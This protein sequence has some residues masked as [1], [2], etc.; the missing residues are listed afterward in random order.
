MPSPIELC[1]QCKDK[2]ADAQYYRCTAGSGREAGLSIQSDGTL[3]WC[4]PE[5]SALD[6]WVGDDGRLMVYRSADTPEAYVTRRNRR[7]LLPEE[8][9]ALIRNRDELSV[10][11]FEFTVFVH[12]EAIAVHPPTPVQVVRAAALAASLTLGVAGTACTEATRGGNHPHENQTDSAPESFGRDSDTDGA[13]GSDPAGDSD[14]MIVDFDAGFDSDGDGGV[15]EI[16]DTP[17]VPV[18]K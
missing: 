17:P 4:S 1:I 9:G 8:R 11:G 5:A 15:V 16:I 18:H 2:P 6:I 10:G 3:G 14:T 12:G 13:P 7:M